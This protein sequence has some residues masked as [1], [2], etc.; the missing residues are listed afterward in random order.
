MYRYTHNLMYIRTYIQLL[1]TECHNIAI[2]SV[3]EHSHH[4]LSSQ[5]VMR[6]CLD[7]SCL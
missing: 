3:I 7:A 1:Q 5:D 2:M 6:V 4:V